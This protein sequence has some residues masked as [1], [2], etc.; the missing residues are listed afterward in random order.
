MSDRDLDIVVFGASGV[1]G[2]RVAAYLAQ[3]SAETDLRW[4]AAARNTDRLLR[5]LDE[6]G[7]EAP[8]TLAADLSD[9]SSL[10]RWPR[11]PALC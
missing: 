10:G 11:E 3:R 4:A 9:P 8:E 6:D 2:R 5:L 7:V 1:T